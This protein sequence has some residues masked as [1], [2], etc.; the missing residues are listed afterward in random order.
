MTGEQQGILDKYWDEFADVALRGHKPNDDLTY[1]R[2]IWFAGVVAVM[3][4]IT[5]VQDIDAVV[6]YVGELVRDMDNV[7]KRE[8]ATASDPNKPDPDV[9]YDGS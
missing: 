4:H 6:G 9:C 7:A 2:R 8:M 5:R 3:N 1:E